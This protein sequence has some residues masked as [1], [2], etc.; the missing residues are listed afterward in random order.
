MASF[1]VIEDRVVVCTAILNVFVKHPNITWC[2]NRDNNGPTPATEAAVIRGKC[3]RELETLDSAVQ[4][5]SRRSGLWQIKKP[6]KVQ[7]STLLTVAGEEALEIFNT[8]GLTDEDKVKID[9]VIRKF[10][11]YCTPKK[12]V[13]YELHVF[14]TRAQGAT[15]RVDA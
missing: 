9:V 11:E 14:N 3:C 7:C 1:S 4:A 12:N 5:L 6:A 15:E 2:Q 10:E 8:F 13:T